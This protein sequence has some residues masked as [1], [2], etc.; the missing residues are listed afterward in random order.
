VGRSFPGNLSFRPL[1]YSIPLQI[2]PAEYWDLHLQPCSHLPKHK[3]NEGEYLHSK[4]W[5]E[6]WKKLSCQVPGNLALPQKWCSAIPRLGRND[7]GSMRK[8]RHVSGEPFSKPRSVLEAEQTTFLS[9]TIRVQS[10]FQGQLHS[11]R[12]GRLQD[13]LA[14]QVKTSSAVH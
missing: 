6:E 12:G 11:G 4:E 3:M 9:R 14:Q 1:P 5:K 13:T 2:P 10:S 7:E 8:T